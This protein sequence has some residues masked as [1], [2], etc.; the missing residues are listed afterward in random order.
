M[1]VSGGKGRNEGRPIQGIDTFNT[2]PHEFHQWCRNEGRPIQGIDTVPSSDWTYFLLPA[3]EMKVAPFR[4]LTHDA[5]LLYCK[6]NNFVEMKV[7]PFRALT[8]HCFWCLSLCYRDCRNEG[9]PIQGIDSLLCHRS[10]SHI[11]CRNEG[12]PIQGIDTH[13]YLFPALS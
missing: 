9:R 7:A 5:D 8:Q 2:L 13:I 4:A 11:L 1:R 6:L 10:Q 3:V 12:R